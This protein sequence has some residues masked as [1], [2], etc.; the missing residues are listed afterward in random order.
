[1]VAL[2]T[3]IILHDYLSLRSAITFNNLK[4]VKKEATKSVRYYTMQMTYF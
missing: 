4:A 2:V 1:M 3:I